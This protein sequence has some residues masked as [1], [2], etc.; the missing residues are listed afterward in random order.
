M[1]R[2]GGF[3]RRLFKTGLVGRGTHSEFFGLRQGSIV[4]E[5]SQEIG[6]EDLYMMSQRNNAIRKSIQALRDYLFKSGYYW[7]KEY[8]KKCRTCDYKHSVDS[9]PAECVRCG[10]TEFV[11]PDPLLTAD[12]DKFFKRVDLNGHTLQEILKMYED[13]L[14]VADDAFLV[15]AKD[16]E[17]EMDGSIK[18]WTVKELHVPDPRTFKLILDAQTQVPGGLW[19]MCLRHRPVTYKDPTTHQERKSGRVYQAPGNCQEC[20]GKLNDVWIL[21]G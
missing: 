2:D 5:R 8:S 12:I 4:V 3:L 6:L 16:Y 7:E 20:G 19:W 1:A 9:N 21:V 10:G 18:G 15:V 17:F 11:Q 13:H 14:N